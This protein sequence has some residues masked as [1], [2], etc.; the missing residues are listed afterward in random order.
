MSEESKKIKST[1]SEKGKAQ[2]KPGMNI[3][4]KT[5]AKAKPGLSIKPKKK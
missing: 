1:E 5:G 3:K 4:P 2:P